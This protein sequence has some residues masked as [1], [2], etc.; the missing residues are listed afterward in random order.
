[1]VN[2]RRLVY[3]KYH[4]SYPI[5][6]HTMVLIVQLAKFI[7]IESQPVERIG[8][9][10]TSFK[11]DDEKGISQLASYQSKKIASPIQSLCVFIAV[12]LHLSESRT[13]ARTKSMKKKLHQLKMMTMKALLKFPIKIKKTITYFDYKQLPKII[14]LYSLSFY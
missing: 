5:F 1:M 9:R 3:C 2:R 7:I 11:N 13:V 6:P 4:V 14:S 8:W 10:K 12:F